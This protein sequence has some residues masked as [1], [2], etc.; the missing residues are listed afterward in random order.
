MDFNTIGLFILLAFVA[1]SQW[2]IARLRYKLKNHTHLGVVV[3]RA[4]QEASQED[5][6]IF[7]AGDKVRAKDTAGFHRGANGEVVFQEP[8]GKRC[9][10]LRDGASSP[11]FYYNYE[12]ES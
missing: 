12:L 11:C 8:S 9:W 6:P 7:Q 5:T 4:S 1:E 3:A 10:V 2:A